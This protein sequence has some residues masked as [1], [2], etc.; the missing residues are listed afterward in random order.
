MKKNYTLLLLVFTF[1][2]FAQAPANY[3]N[4]ATGTG[5]VLKTQLKNIIDD[6]NAQTYNDLWT[7]YT[8][9]AFRDNYYENNGSLLDMYSENPSGTDSYEYTT[10]NDQCGNYNSEGDCYNREHLIAQSYFNEATPMKTDAFHVVP[11]DG[12]VNGARGNL[13]F[14]VVASANYTSANGS[15]RGSNTVNAFSNY[16]GTVFEPLDEF[17]GDVARAFFYFATRYQDQMPGFYTAANAASTQVKAMFDGSSDKV[18]SDDFILLMIKWHKQDAVSAKETAYNNAIYS[19]QGNRNPFIDNADY[20]CTIW[21]S[22]CA[23]VDAL[24]TDDFAAMASISV[25][26]NPSNGFITIRSEIGLDDIQLINING[27]LIQHIQKPA[28]INNQYALDNLPKGFYLLKLSSENQSVTK[29]V[30][31]N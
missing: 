29:K 31:V 6:H 17:K 15:K 26:P 3:Y 27:Q 28:S 23:T 25:Y 16:S 4:T 18:F 2:G 8:Q 1:I 11:S 12:S 7:L 22:Y 10:T 13:P 19:Y 30:I 21:T 20:V 9:T 24:S 14:G 5:Y